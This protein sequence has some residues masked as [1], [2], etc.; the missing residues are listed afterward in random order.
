MLGTK[1]AL[2]FMVSLLLLFSLAPAQD[3]NEA[4]QKGN[5]EK[6][7]ELVKKDPQLLNKIGND[8]DPPLLPA[9]SGGHKEVIEYLLSKGVD[10][11]SKNSSGQNAVT[12]TAYAG[13]LE[14][15]K[16][17]V[18]K[19]AKIVFTDRQGM[20]PLHFA[21]Q[22]G[23]LP[24]VEFLVSK[25]A[26]LTGKNRGGR[27][28]LYL[29]AIRGHDKVMLFLL[30][31]GVSATTKDRNGHSPL[32]GAIDRKHAKAA[33][34]LLEKGKLEKEDIQDSMLHLAALRGLEELVKP[35]L[36]RGANME[37]KNERGGSFLHSTAMGG[38]TELCKKIVQ[39]GAD[40]NGKDNRGRTLLHY[41][42]RA[43]NTALVE[44]LLTSGADI[45]AA[46]KNGTTALDI[47]QNRTNTPLVKGLKK[48]GAKPGT[49]KIYDL[50]REKKKGNKTLEITYIGNEGFLLS[51]GGKKILLDALQE[52]PWS[53]DNIPPD[54]KKKI[55]AATPPY[56][57]LDL[58][59]ASHAHLDHFEPKMTAA[60]MRAHPEM[61]FISSQPAV[62]QLKEAA[63]EHF[64]ELAKRVRN[65]TPKWDTLEETSYKG[66]GVKL[67]PVNHS[68]RQPPYMTLAALVNLEGIKLFHL[69]DSVA[70]SNLES[71]K[72]LELQKEG[73]DILFADKFFLSDKIG[74]EILKN[75]LKPKLIIL[76][77][78]RESETD[79]FE[80][81]LKPDYPNL[82]IFKDSMQKKYFK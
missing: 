21:A 34:L 6:I 71:F 47:A 54:T 5:L 74:K 9:A 4:A 14:I 16:L 78:A 20:S 53:Y 80:K 3:I 13:N 51:I 10:A 72:K 29:A 39:K 17:L 42:V 25:G 61:V 30:G 60:A 7:K 73:I 50:G 66:I 11:N 45:D 27:T 2:V 75:Y 58:N 44:F 38:L 52:N 35:L 69:A 8:G 76:M 62:N 67:M 57:K 79:T 46:D 43:G 31:K 22:Q 48:R 70:A 36:D 41:A 64:A 68:S 77:H 33:L 37:S 23:H 18:S 81:E 26:P 40:V 55:L 65:I 12:Y 82:I 56:D 15:T 32:Y 24:V 63:G 1:F 59:I 49:H 19:G 28:P